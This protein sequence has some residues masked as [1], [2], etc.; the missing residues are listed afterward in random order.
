MALNLHCAMFIFYL[1]TTISVIS[2]VSLVNQS[3]VHRYEICANNNTTQTDCH[4]QSLDEIST[5]VQ[6][7]TNVQ[8][9]IQ[10]TKVQLNKTIIF[11]NLTSLSI[12]G[13]SK[14]NTTIFCTISGTIGAGIVLKDISGTVELNYLAVKKCGTKITVIN[15]A[16]FLSALT[17]LNCTNVEVVDLAIEKSNGI[18]LMMENYPGSRV[19]I[20][21]TTFN[22]NRLQYDNN[23]L[24]GGGGGVFIRIKSRGL[25]LEQCLRSTE[26]SFDNCTFQENSANN[27][28]SEYYWNSNTTENLL[29]GYGRGGGVYLLL[30][31]G[32]RNVNVSFVRSIFARNQAYIGGGLAVRISAI[33]ANIRV[34]IMDSVFEQNSCSDN[35][36]NKKKVVDKGGGAHLTFDSYLE[37]SNVT[38]SH[39]VLSSVHFK[40][41]S[42]T[43]GGG[44]YHFS[45]IQETQDKQN[46]ML[47]DNC[48]FDGNQAHIGAAILLAPKF[49]RRILNGI[50]VLVMIKNS[51]FDSNI[52]LPQSQNYGYPA[53]IAGWGTVYISSYDMQFVGYNNFENNSGSALYVVNGVVNFKESDVRFSNN[54]GLQGGA[55]ALTG[56]SFV[57]FG[58]KSY[59]FINNS[60]EYQGGALYISVIDKFDFVNKKNCFIQCVD[61]EN[62]TANITFR[63]NTVENNKGGQSIFATSLRPCMAITI[64]TKE[65][66]QL[67]V[68]VNNSEV[69]TSRGMKFVDDP[70]QSH[71][72]IA[73]D[74]AMLKINNTSSLKIFPGQEV[75]HGV[76]A[77][78]DLGDDINASFW[79]V[80]ESEE[81]GIQLT[82]AYSTVI[83]N[84]IQVKSVPKKTANISFNVQSPV[85]VYIKMNLE[86]LECPPG[87]RLVKNKCHCHTEVHKGLIKCDQQEFHS[88]IIPGFWIGFVKPKHSLVT[89]W[90]RFCQ[91]NLTSSKVSI[92]DYHLRLPQNISELS[93]AL[94]GET[95]EGIVCG[96]CRKGYTVH[97]HSP[98]YLCKPAEP[99]GCKL[100]WLFYILSELVPVTVVFIVVLVLNISFTSGAV[101]GFILFSQLIRSLDLSAAGTVITPDNLNTKQVYHAFYGFFNL[102][103]FQ[104]ESLSFC[105]WKQASALDMVAVKYITLVYTIILI[106]SIIWIMNRC[107]GRWLG[108]C[109]RITTIQTSVI[110]GITSFLMIGYAQCVNTSLSLLLH[111]HIYTAE[112]SDIK[113]HERVWLNGEMKYFSKEHL[114]YAILAIFFLVTI[115]CLP[116]VL[117]ISY[118]LLNKVI[119]ILGIEERKYVAIII[120][121]ISNSNLKPLLDSFQGC[122]KDNLRF[123]AGLYFLYRW[124]FMLIHISTVGYLAYYTD[125]GIFLVVILTIHTICQPYTRR[126]HNII[127][128][129][130]L[131]IL[132]IINALSLFNFHKSNLLNPKLSNRAVYYALVEQLVLISLPAIAFITYMVIVIYKRFESKTLVTVIHTKG[133]RKLRDLFQRLKSCPWSKTLQREEVNDDSLVDHDVVFMSVCDYLEQREALEDN[134]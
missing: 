40:Q 22:E 56:T 10:I 35:E 115:G 18:G 128:A 66:K 78:N 27:S 2:S 59:E 65:H 127:D 63:R 102:E 76:V 93:N 39:Y 21:S 74:A 54:R 112:N 6:N 94:C 134:T 113:P 107:G 67:D 99:V 48:V 124:I 110:H 86:I 4:P 47:L 49:D 84:K 90:C 111:V 32:L 13:N 88:Y 16:T 73:T 80:I 68:I 50:S 85:E 117:L 62:C 114:P 77:A 5:I 125:I 81:D 116:P 75:N 91:P 53:E 52:V 1:F 123:F 70:D 97:F 126:L 51:S 132:V 100:G 8:I 122:F 120:G 29:A 25:P 104:L 131:C 118:P 103:F 46:A 82:S 37:E 30:D 109:F 9:N 20:E 44:L 26:I 14:L 130:L 57:V 31:K 42:A 72:Q 58:P 108:K 28:Y 119:A 60:A 79:A 24:Y 55:I 12:N 87:F 129:L 121:F 98:G 36:G 7:Q 17:I 19:C 106:V 43:L 69:F 92:D 101:N 33:N 11:E 61:T 38:K 89:S 95:R 23:S 3:I 45:G 41:N 71:N 15:G 96:K 64:Y 34:M 83:T 105:L 133:K